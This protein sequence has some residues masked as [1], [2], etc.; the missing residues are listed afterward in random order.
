MKRPSRLEILQYALEGVCMIRG[1][2]PE[3][4]NYPEEIEELDAHDEW[5]RKEI[6]RVQQQEQT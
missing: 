4:N 2:H 6:D 5:L 3:P 1:T